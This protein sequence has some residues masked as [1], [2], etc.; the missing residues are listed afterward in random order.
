VISATAIA[1]APHAVAFDLLDAEFDNRWREW[2]ARGRANE[3][4]VR[5]RLAVSLAVALPAAL[6]I[7]LARL[8][9]TS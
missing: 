7:L 4:R 8:L 1:P 5:G 3:Q 2:K 6:A 9:L